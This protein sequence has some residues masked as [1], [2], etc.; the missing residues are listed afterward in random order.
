MWNLEWQRVIA[1]WQPVH[2]VSLEEDKWAIK[3]GEEKKAGEAG[4]RHGNSAAVKAARHIPGNRR[5]RRD[6]H[7]TELIHDPAL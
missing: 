1:Q 4:Q 5:E 7:Q 6:T 2:R 3:R